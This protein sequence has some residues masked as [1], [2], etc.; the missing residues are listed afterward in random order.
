MPE[1]EVPG[2][3][4]IEERTELSEIGDAEISLRIK[5][6][7]FDLYS[8][9]KESYGNN[10]HLLVR[11]FRPDLIKHLLEIDKLEY[12]D[13][14]S[15][16]R[17]ESKARGFA[18]CKKGQWEV[19][20]RED[21]ELEYEAETFIFY[22]IT[23]NSPLVPR[24]FVVNER[25]F[26][27]CPKVAEEKIF[28][29][30]KNLI[31]YK[32]SEQYQRRG[33]ELEVNV[34]CRERLMPCI[35]KIYINP[36]L[37]SGNYWVARAILRN[38][39]EGA[40]ED[41]TI[42]YRIRGYSDWS[43]PSHYSLL[44]PGGTI[45]DWY[46]PELHSKVMTLTSE[47][48]ANLE[49]EYSYKGANP[50]S[51]S[52]VI[53]IRGKNAFEYSDTEVWKLKASDWYARFTNVPLLA[54]FVTKN[55]PPVRE[56]VDMVSR[57]SGGVAAKAKDEY[58][59]AWIG[60]FYNLEKENG[61]NY[62]TPSKGIMKSV[63]EQEIKYPR[64]VLRGKAGTCIDLAILYTA[65][66]EATG[67]KSFLVVIPGHCFPLFLLPSGCLFP[68][69]STGIGKASFQEACESAEN[70]WKKAQE[71]GGYLLVDIDEWQRRGVYSPELPSLSE[72]CLE[73]WGIRIPQKAPSPKETRFYRIMSALKD[74]AAPPA[75]Q[76]TIPPTHL[77]PPN[78]TGTWVGTIWSTAFG[79]RA[80]IDLQLTQ[81]RSM[82]ISSDIISYPPLQARFR[83]EG[84]FFD[85]LG[86]LSLSG[87]TPAGYFTFNPVVQGNHLEGNYTLMNLY[88]MDFGTISADKRS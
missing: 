8:D 6:P 32:L 55:D 25:V 78:L 33:G 85:L 82:T 65:C 7:S 58:A 60:A 39:G 70:T 77:R 29:K 45:V 13:T 16:L 51:D 73:D 35:Y 61:F 52:K 71:S 46:Y 67:I 49:I 83:L 38:R 53:Y 88:A 21:L 34:E 50:V 14:N 41:I 37:E 43:V 44:P 23:R 26:R 79:L 64:E 18:V 84:M 2:T 28:N 5:F 54:A 20:V 47:T 69:E 66:C 3:L 48:P 63:V 19:S 40:L 81:S 1:Q 36:K 31:T 24:S 11:K 74:T 57:Y 76:P 72:N 68:V 17:I 56:F 62:Q 80:R 12:N 59:K 75:P 4:T 27:E 30:V 42:K 9:Y 15:E 86:T 10:Q 22:C 87:F